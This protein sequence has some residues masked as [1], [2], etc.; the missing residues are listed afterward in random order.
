[1]KT[2]ITLIAALVGSF[3]LSNCTAHVDADVPGAHTSS[4]TNTTTTAAPYTGS[5]TTRRTTT[6]Y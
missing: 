2:T 3:A 6:T 4:H 1:M 5:T